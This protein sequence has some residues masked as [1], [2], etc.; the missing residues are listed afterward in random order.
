[1]FKGVKT[2]KLLIIKLMNSEVVSNEIIIDNLKAHF[3]GLS[4]AENWVRKLDSES[5]YHYY[6]HSIT[7]ESK[8]DESEYNKNTILDKPCTSDKLSA[9][10]KIS[11]MYE[12]NN[13]SEI[14]KKIQSKQ[15]FKN[16]KQ[17]NELNPLN[18]KDEPIIQIDKARSVPSETKTN[19]QSLINLYDNKVPECTRNDKIIAEVLSEFDPID[20]SQNNKIIDTSID[21]LFGEN[22]VKLSKIKTPV[23]KK[24][25][26]A[27]A[28]NSALELLDELLE[29]QEKLQKVK[30]T[31]ETDS[32]IIKTINPEMS[33]KTFYL[34]DNL[35]NSEIDVILSEPAIKPKI[36]TKSLSMRR[37]PKP[38]GCPPPQ[39]PHM[40]SG[41]GGTI[42]N[43]RLGKPRY[44]PKIIKPKIYKKPN[45]A[46]PKL[47][48]Q[49]ISDDN[50]KLGNIVRKDGYLTGYL[51]LKVTSKKVFK[52][53]SNRFFTF[54][55]GKLKMWKQIEDFKNDFVPKNTYKIDYNKNYIVSNIKI[56]TKASLISYFTMYS[57]KKEDK[58][59]ANVKEEI[60]IG[61][62]NSRDLLKLNHDLNCY[63]LFNKIH[64]N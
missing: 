11:L 49:V 22:E 47:E 12:I 18:K 30:K 44:K 13:K 31:F 14:I 9:S 51:K 27:S 53:W 54:K 52:K 7:G 39:K 57:F 41:K 8:W 17:F 62:I 50:I 2:S 26:S 42:K 5:G 64:E 35:K 59:K 48:E 33:H 45:Y 56:S 24:D 28:Y 21:L 1:M 60:T 4:A 20:N 6:E 23:S 38:P 29:E 58:F 34:D 16:I 15:R 3:L 10:D 32:F 36:P 40:L 63:T 19:I 43:N 25:K 61:S 46:P 55:E 37:K